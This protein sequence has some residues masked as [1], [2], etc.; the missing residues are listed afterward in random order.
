MALGAGDDG[1]DLE[2]QIGARL[3][4]FGVDLRIRQ[5]QVGAERAE[6]R[7]HWHVVL[8][9]NAEGALEDLHVLLIVATK[10]T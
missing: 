9:N 7:L 3:Q 2:L 6:A 5:V 10:L 8:L 1:L 4:H